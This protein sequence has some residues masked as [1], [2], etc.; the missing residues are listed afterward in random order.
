VAGAG[1]YVV[2][3]RRHSVLLLATIRLMSEPPVAI[4]MPFAMAHPGG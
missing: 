2:R 3:H 1:I 4:C